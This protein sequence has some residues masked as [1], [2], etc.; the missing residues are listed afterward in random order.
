M[1]R[2]EHDDKGVRTWKEFRPYGPYVERPDGS[3]FWSNDKGHLHRVDGPAAEWSDGEQ[4]WFYNGSLHR[5]DGPAVSRPD[6]YERWMIHGLEHRYVGPAIIYPVGTKFWY[7]NGRYV[8]M[9]CFQ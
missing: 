8:R 3:K 1:L 5:F 2:P 7:E 4:K 6:G 9:E